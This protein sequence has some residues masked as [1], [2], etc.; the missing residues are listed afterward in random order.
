MYAQIPEKIASAGLDE[1]RALAT[2]LCFALEAMLV[3]GGP[4]ARRDARNALQAAGR[5]MGGPS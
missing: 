4:E 2:L 5:P 3:E 1:L